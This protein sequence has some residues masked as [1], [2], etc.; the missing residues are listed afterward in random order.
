MI[1]GWEVYRNVTT[2]SVV[3]LKKAGPF[4][5]LPLIDWYRKNP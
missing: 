4:L 3:Q 2:C 5:A 1:Q